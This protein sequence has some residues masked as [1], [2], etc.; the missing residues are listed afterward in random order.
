MI[1]KK[2]TL[3]CRLGGNQDCFGE[4]NLYYISKL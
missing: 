4:Y 2:L 1:E 3:Y